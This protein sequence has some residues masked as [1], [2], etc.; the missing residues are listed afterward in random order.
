MRKNRKTA[1]YLFPPLDIYHCL[2]YI[3]FTLIFMLCVNV[4]SLLSLLE[5]NCCQSSLT[6]HTSHRSTPSATYIH[7]YTH[8]L[9]QI[10]P[11]L[12]VFPFSHNIIW[13]SIILC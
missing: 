8:T 11:L 4:L 3:S 12:D 13:N 6:P 7:I 5:V 1:W 2:L 10:Y 9:T